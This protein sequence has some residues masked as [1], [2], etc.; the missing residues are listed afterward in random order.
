MVD[1]SPV[2]SRVS[3]IVERMGAR[4]TLPVL[5]KESR[6]RMRGVRGQVLLFLTTALAIVVGL[7]I[8]VPE[9]DNFGDGL[10]MSS[11]GN[12]MAAAGK[13]LFIGLI[14]LQGIICTLVTPALTAGAI[15]IER[16]QQTLDLLLLTRLSSTNIV[17]GK[18]L[19]SVSFVMM[20]LFSALPVAA[21]SFILGGVDPGQLFWSLAVILAS[22][23]LFGAIALHC[24]TRYPR[25]STAV[26]VGYGACIFW[27][28][29]V[30]GL[31]GG[32]GAVLD[33]SPDLMGPSF[34]WVWYYG[35]ISLTS[36]VLSLIPTTLITV[37]STAVLRRSWS[38]LANII[39]WAFFTIAMFVLVVS[40]PTAVQKIAQPQYFL[41]GNPI[42]ALALL[43]HPEESMGSGPNPALSTNLFAAVTMFLL[44]LGAWIFIVL[45]AGEMSR[46]RHGMRDPWTAIKL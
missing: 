41:L 34:Y 28:S 43:I 5:M 30:P 9:W 13:A 24:S 33:T 18:L 22:V 16:E 40:F 25:T 7:I 14:I 26:V 23:L 29:L 39:M 3:P 42:V 44:L 12:Q 17:L 1:M 45:A 27:L 32:L 6:S 2:M 38:R 15:S 35:L 37:F 20:I 46:L 31:V 8:I 19:S 21:I 10:D 11:G 36:A 4:L